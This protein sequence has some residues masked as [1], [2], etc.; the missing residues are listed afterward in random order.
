MLQ[1]TFV[2]FLTPVL[3]LDMQQL[4]QRTVTPPPLKAWSEEPEIRYDNS[5]LISPAWIPQFTLFL[6]HH[7]NISR[8]G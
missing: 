7:Q 2:S 3:S 5:V 4:S 6:E 8:V 1:G